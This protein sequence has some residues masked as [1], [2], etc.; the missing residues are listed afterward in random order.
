MPSLTFKPYQQLV[1]AA[2]ASAT[3]LRTEAIK[4]NI[5]FSL[6]GKNNNELNRIIL[7]TWAGSPENHV[8]NKSLA[9]LFGTTLNLNELY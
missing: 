2:A 1:T 3:I 9:L 8:I 6:R 5:G 4:S 7:G